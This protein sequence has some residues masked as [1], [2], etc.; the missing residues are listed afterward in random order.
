MAR[1]T[2]ASKLARYRDKVEASRQWRESRGYID[3]WRRM[4]DLYRGKL[5]HTDNSDQALVNMAF[6]VAN[7]VVASVTT[8][9]P[10]FTVAPNVMG[11]DDKAIIAEAVL[12]Y[13]WKHY[14]FHDEFQLAIVDAM[15]LGHG[16]LKVGWHYEERK[17]NTPMSPDEQMALAMQTQAQADQEAAQAGSMQEAGQLPTDQEIEQQV[18]PNTSRVEV[19]KDD[20]FVE[21]VSP[22]DVVI[23]PEA[24]SMRELRWIAH[25]TVRDLKLVRDDGNYEPAG[26]KA[27]QADLALSGNHDDEYDQDNNSTFNADEA[28]DTDR[29]TVWELYNL[30]DDEWCT[31]AQVGEGYLRKPQPIPTDLFKN[32]FVMFRD[33]DVPDTFYP[34]GEIESMESLQE[35]LNKTRTQQIETRKQFIRK[36]IGRESAL[37][38]KAREALTSEIDGDV[39]LVTEDDRPLADMIIQAPSLTFDPQL[40]NA[41]SQQIV[42]D[43]QMTTGL[44]DYQFGQ[45]PDTR[46]LATEAMA[47]EGATNARSSYKLSRIERDLATAGRYLLAIMQQYLDTERVARVA[48]PGG[49]MLFSYTADDIE[50]EYDLN[51]EAGSTQPKNDM[52]RRQETVTLFQTL[53]PYMGTLIDPQELIRYLLQQGYDIKNV[54]RFM[55]QQQPMIDPATG[56]PM[57]DPATGMP[58]QGQPGQPGMPGAPGMPGQGGPGMAQPP[59]S[60]PPQSSNGAGAPPA[61][62]PPVP[63]GV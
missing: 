34:I 4:I 6:A 17:V 63:A 43:M 27:A 21:R 9:Y 3:T 22:F 36:F 1:E 50:G 26:R 33:Y 24:T 42:G 53:A 46:R 55:V 51:V 61:S 58:M 18:G 8:Q 41:H 13:A 30:Q 11:Q 44:S 57:I 52:I 49:E 2:Q 28:Q 56:Q 37:N 31:F 32:P 12:N 38:E 39:A 5:D 47:V 48:G 25:R 23:D 54:D 59:A 7:I 45:M 20:P 62:Q 35:E 16:W 19:V 14:E 40:F 15:M 29:V 60:A 10:K